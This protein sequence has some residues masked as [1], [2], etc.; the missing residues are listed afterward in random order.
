MPDGVAK[1]GTIR[2]GSGAVVEEGVTLGSRDDGVL[3]IG[4]GAYIRSGSVIYSDVT[5]GS[6]FRCGHNILIREATTIGDNTLVGTNSV[7]D[8]HC[9]VGSSVSVQ[10]GVYI[11][12]NTTLEDGVF[13]GPNSV[14]TNDK[15]MEHGALLSG[16]IIKE[17]A[18]IG[19]NATI[20]P[21]VTVG[22]GAVVGAGSVV[23][24][25]VAAGAVVAGNP[26]RVLAGRYQLCD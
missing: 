1:R 9:V 5:I 8:G 15:H 12:R 24:R 17:G 3:V 18:R 13:M 6:G 4:D 2:L 14:T 26:A 19:A 10:T 21:G 20:L 7:L 22:R 11:T 23:T 25:D 16:P